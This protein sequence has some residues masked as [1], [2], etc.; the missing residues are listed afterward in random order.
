MRG[1][2]RKVL[3][4]QHFDEI[5]TDMMRFFKLLL[6][7]NHIFEVY[8][9]CPIHV[10]QDIRQGVFDTY[11]RE[12]FADA[13]VQYIIGPEHHWPVNGE[14]G[15]EY[16]D[17]FPDLLQAACTKHGIAAPNRFT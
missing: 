5:R 8:Q 15:S 10:R 7:N 1:F 11:D 17:K 2:N 3:K 4:K 9:R 6:N 12:Y 13:L 14:I 16:S